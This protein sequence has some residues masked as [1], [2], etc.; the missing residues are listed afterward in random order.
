MTHS[1]T[2]PPSAISRS[3]QAVVFAVVTLLYLVTSSYEAPWGEGA[4]AQLRAL[5]GWDF[6]PDAGHHPLTTLVI[7]LFVLPWAMA[8]HISLGTAGCSAVLG[9]LAA[10]FFYR[11][12]RRT[13]LGHTGAS[14]SAFS[15]AAAHAVWTG[16][17]AGPT[18]PLY[19]L[20]LL[21]TIDRLMAFDK[22]RPRPLY[23]AAF[24]FGLGWVHHR[25]YLPAVPGILLYLYSRR[26]DL[27]V[28]WFKPAAVAA[29]VGVS[30]MILSSILYLASGRDI[31]DLGHTYLFSETDFYKDR[32]LGT[33]YVDWGPAIEYFVGFWAYNF[34]GLGLILGL[35]GIPLALA[36][37][38]AANWWIWPTAL[39][40]FIFAL[41]YNVAEPWRMFV[42]AFLSFAVFVGFG[43]QEL[44]RQVMGRIS[45]SRHSVAAGLVTA[46]ISGSMIVMPTLADI[47]T[48][49]ALNLAGA[50]PFQVADA[51]DYH[52]QFLNPTCPGSPTAGRFAAD[53][54]DALP[55]DAVVLADDRTYGPLALTNRVSA[56]TSGITVERL[57]GS[58]AKDVKRQA[59][60]WG[61]ERPVFAVLG[62][63]HKLDTG[64]EMHRIGRAYHGTLPIYL[65]RAPG[66][67]WAGS[68][69]ICL[70]HDGKKGDAGKKLSSK[71]S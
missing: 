64:H 42:P 66:I 35:V 33:R 8:D 65:V 29:L 15:F 48:P 69:K 32:I 60:A 49:M 44:W 57:K 10:M 55:A 24:L 36:R 18:V 30:P 52:R 51:G 67:G 21:A 9:G 71:R 6:W 12:M 47:V 28:G 43:A 68:E 27:P 25:F 41:K 1:E 2:A 20:I 23:E 5:N 54:L 39:V 50:N 59:K 45:Y 14:A 31:I 62:P 34:A 53:V 46:G 22:Q 37:A 16:V 70:C 13:G 19:A 7:K 56:K 17:H 63:F 3:G 61:D 58:D 4:V 26:R 40:H 38:G 11:V